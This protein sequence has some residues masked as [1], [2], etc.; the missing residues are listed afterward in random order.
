MMFL[1]RLI[2]TGMQ[3]NPYWYSLTYNW[4]AKDDLWL[5]NCTNYCC[6]RS[7]EVCGKNVK[8][9]IPRG[10]AQT[11]Y[12]ASKWIGAKVPKVGAICV[13]GGGQYGHVGIVERINKDGTVVISQSNYTRKSKADMIANYFVI[14]TYKPMVGYI[15]K[16]IGWKFLGYLYNP[17]VVDKRVNRDETRRQVEVTAERVRAR[18][19]PGG[20]AYKGQFIPMGIY[21]ILEE[22][23]DWLRVDDNVWFSKG[24]W[25]TIYE[26]DEL[27]KELEE[28]IKQRDALNAKIDELKKRLGL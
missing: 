17:Y 7:S 4:F 21:N 18:K 20:D 11:W 26:A 24:E 22:Q 23:G 10:N 14:G 13:W 27:R 3:D 15:T 2:Q 19:S 5:P 12:D 1:E 28:L 6:G 16:G 9:E 25:A 8:L